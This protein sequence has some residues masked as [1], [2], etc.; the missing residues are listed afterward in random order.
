MYNWAAGNLMVPPAVRYPFDLL[1]SVYKWVRETT[2]YCMFLD[3][4]H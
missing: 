3:Q 4:G 1:M 2:V